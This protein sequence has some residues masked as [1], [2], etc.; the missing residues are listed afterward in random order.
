[1][2]D[3]WGYFMETRKRHPKRKREERAFLGSE[4][5]KYYF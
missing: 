1:V 4:G 2:Y 3:S 5:K